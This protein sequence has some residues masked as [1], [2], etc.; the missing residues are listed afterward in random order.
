MKH[1]LVTLL[2]LSTPA[3]ADNAIT[4]HTNDV[5]APAYNN[6]TLLD[7]EKAEKI[8][9]QLIDADTCAKE[10][11]SYEK[12]IELYKNNQVLYQDENSMLLGKNIELS[13]ALNDSRSMSDWQKVAFF[14][15]GV[16]VTGAA[17]WGAS[18]LV[19]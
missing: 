1:L 6:G 18:R 4:V 15:L 16:V 11:Q 19:K 7:K 9:D 14:T 5:V 13:K 10:A 12:S 3:Y 17:V 8:K 2:I